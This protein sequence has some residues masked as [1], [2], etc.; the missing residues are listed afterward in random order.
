MF[1]FQLLIFDLSS[2]TDFN[3]KLSMETLFY[4]KLLH[5]CLLKMIYSVTMHNEKNID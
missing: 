5:I 2:L 3:I 1:N 4:K